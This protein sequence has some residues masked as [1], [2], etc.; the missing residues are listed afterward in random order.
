MG[1]DI[2]YAMLDYGGDIQEFVD[3][4]MKLAGTFRCVG[5][6][7]S[8]LNNLI[9]SGLNAVTDHVW[10]DVHSVFKRVHG[11]LTTGA[12]D[13]FLDVVNLWSLFLPLRQVDDLQDN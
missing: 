1:P 6:L 11:I 7:S 10:E 8:R 9:D 12:L 5:Q 3:V 13:L 4:V 2:F